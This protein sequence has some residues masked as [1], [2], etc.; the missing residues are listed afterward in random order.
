[1]IGD[2]QVGE[3]CKDRV[4]MGEDVVEKSVVVVGLQLKS[5]EILDGTFVPSRLQN[6]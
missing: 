6:F 2:V 3:V 5:A 4:D 1:M